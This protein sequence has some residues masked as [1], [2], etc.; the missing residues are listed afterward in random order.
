MLVLRLTPPQNGSPIA[1]LF[2]LR[3]EFQEMDVKSPEQ[4]ILGIHT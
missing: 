3:P 4:E 1:S 2:Q